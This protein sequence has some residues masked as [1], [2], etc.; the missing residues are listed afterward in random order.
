MAEASSRIPTASVWHAETALRG[1]GRL[2]VGTVKRQSRRHSVTS[3]SPDENVRQRCPKAR[4]TSWPR[5]KLAASALAPSSPTS[6]QQRSKP[7]QS[8]APT[9]YVFAGEG[10]LY[11]QP[12][13]RMQAWIAWIQPVYLMNAYLW[14]SDKPWGLF[15]VMLSSLTPI[16]AGQK[17]KPFWKS[18]IL[19]RLKSEMLAPLSLSLAHMFFR[20]TRT[21]RRSHSEVGSALARVLSE[22]W[23]AAAAPWIHVVPQIGQTHIKVGQPQLKYS[24]ATHCFR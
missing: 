23:D 6:R 15:S 3:S 13:Y 11:R 2:S 12:T 4:D 21:G 5:G 24:E 10:R 16:A 8:F 20:Q 9:R 17:P 22:Y 18:F 14:H 1:Q 19:R 7:R